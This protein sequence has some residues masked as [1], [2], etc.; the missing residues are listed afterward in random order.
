[1]NV[2]VSAIA[3]IEAQFC[4]MMC[5]LPFR[6]SMHSHKPRVIKVLLIS[7]TARVKETKMMARCIKSQS[8]TLDVSRHFEA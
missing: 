7:E 2:D 1:M 4:D 3:S 8:V 6:F 5:V